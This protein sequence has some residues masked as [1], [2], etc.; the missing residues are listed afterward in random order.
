MIDQ[1]WQQEQIGPGVTRCPIDLDAEITPL[2]LQALSHELARPT[3]PWPQIV[4]QPQRLPLRKRLTRMLRAAA[5]SQQTY[6]G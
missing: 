1:G 4:W 3:Q 6:G 5:M 2:D